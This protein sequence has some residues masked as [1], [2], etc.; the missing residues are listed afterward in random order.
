VDGLH[1]RGRRLAR[2]LQWRPEWRVAAG[3][4][5]AW[6]ALLAGLGMHRAHLGPDH[7]PAGVM[8]GL[9]GWS[10]MV[11]A[12]MVPVT[13]PAVRYVG[14]NSMRRR[15]RRAMA[16]YTAVYVGAWTLFGVTALGADHL[17][18]VHLGLGEH[19]LLALA[20]VTA[21][22]WQLTRAK[23]RALFACGRT[24]ALP[25][26]GRRADAGCA[27]YALLNAWRCIRSC[28]AIM[29]VMVAVGHS[30]LVW[31]VALTA[32][33]FAEE[34]TV[35]GRRVTRPAAALLLAAAAGVALGF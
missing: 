4:A 31:M 28:W 14:L 6:L 26:L 25:P 34:L 20:L 7:S 23:R 27:R 30:S 5:A 18:R 12:M 22:V 35:R 21:A 16:V 19:V 29:A 17:L 33:V 8:A 13:L 1:A 9:P 24:V 2:T 3:A 15:R 10:L 11:V 32:L